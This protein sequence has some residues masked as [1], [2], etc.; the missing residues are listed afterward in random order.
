MRRG[1]TLL[2]VL[3]ATAIMALAVTAALSALRVSMRNADRQLELDRAASLAGRKMDQL[4]AERVVYP[5]GQNFGGDFPPLYTGGIEAGWTARVT[6][7]DAPVIPP[8]SRTEGLERIQ[9]EVWWNS[10]GV[11]KTM[12]VEGFRRA[13]F[14]ADQVDWMAAHPQATALGAMGAPQ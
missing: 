4:L 9:V 8:T 1:F 7:W 10:S 6:P 5:P 14:T 2:E 13:I 12:T 11:R 3:V